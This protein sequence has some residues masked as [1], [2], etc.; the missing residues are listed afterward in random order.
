MWKKALDLADHVQVDRIGRMFACWMFIYFGQFLK[1]TEVHSRANFFQG[2]SL[3]RW[4]VW[5]FI[6]KREVQ[7]N[8]GKMA[9]K[10]RENTSSETSQR[11]FRTESS[12][13]SR[14]RKLV[15]M[16]RHL[17]ACLRTWKF[18][19]LFANPRDR[20]RFLASN[21]GYEVFCIPYLMKFHHR[22]WSFWISC[23]DVHRFTPGC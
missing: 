16:L 8:G 22:L 11:F 17:E 21:P 19:F 20:G 2:K 6:L 23:L 12:R 4:Y 10:W 15:K 7:N 5:V 9:G 3:R 14:T 1:T 13:V 18:F